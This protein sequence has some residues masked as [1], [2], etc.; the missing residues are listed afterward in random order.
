MGVGVGSISRCHWCADRRGS[1]ARTKFVF[2]TW[3]F[4]QPTVHGWIVGFVQIG[5]ETVQ[6]N[7]CKT[8][9]WPECIL[10]S[11]LRRKKIYEA[12]YPETRRGGLPGKAGGG[13]QAKTEMIPAFA[14]Q[15]ILETRRNRSYHTAGGAD[16]L[17][18]RGPGHRIA[19]DAK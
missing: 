5:Q 7:V 18:H 1:L 13:K 12:R 9:I 14:E 19:P 2:G 10:S 11:H 6:R 16:R 15:C 4:A 17:Q 8:A 3:P